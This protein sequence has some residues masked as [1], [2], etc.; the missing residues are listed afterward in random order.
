MIPIEPLYTRILYS[1]L[2][3][4]YMNNV[5]CNGPEKHTD[6]YQDMATR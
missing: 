3:Y 2:T 6:C 5:I 4:E 1:I